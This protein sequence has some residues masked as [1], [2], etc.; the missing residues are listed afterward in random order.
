MSEQAGLGCFKSK[1]DIFDE[2]IGADYCFA[3]V[4]VLD[5]RSIIANAHAQVC[6]GWLHFSPMSKSINKFEFV[7]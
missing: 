6:G 2:E 7:H 1:V 3:T 5:D 4:R